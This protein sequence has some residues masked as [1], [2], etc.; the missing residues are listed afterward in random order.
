MGERSAGVFGQHFLTKPWHKSRFP[1]SRSR[2][3]HQGLW[4]IFRQDHLHLFPLD[5]QHL[6]WCASGRLYM[7]V[8]SYNLIDSH[9]G[10]Q[11]LG[12]HLVFR[13]KIGVS[14]DY[15]AKLHA[16]NLVQSTNRTNA[17]TETWLVPQPQIQLV[18]LNSRPSR[19]SLEHKA[20]AMEKSEF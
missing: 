14:P 16:Q 8:V 9:G 20:K 11:A 5:C 7:A 1:S 19:P 18:C 10:K 3:C 13:M 4:L 12:R 6:H 17:V 2:G 15:I